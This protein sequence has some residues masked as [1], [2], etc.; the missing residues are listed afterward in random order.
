MD[1][2]VKERLL[3]LLKSVIPKVTGVLIYGSTVRGYADSRS[4]IDICL[5]PKDDANLKDLYKDILHI[6]SDRRY[7]IVIYNQ[8][9]W[10]LRGEILESNEV[11]YAEDGDELDFWLY[12]QMKIWSDMAGRQSPVAAEDLINRIIRPIFL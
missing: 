10:Y 11:I 9:P 8:I 6:S 12:K 7:D 4:D 5:I 2:Q 3:I 1:D